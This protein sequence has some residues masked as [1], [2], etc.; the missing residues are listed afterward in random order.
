[1]LC[2]GLNIKNYRTITVNTNLIMLVEKGIIVTLYNWI[3][4]SIWPFHYYEYK[5]WSH[6]VIL[7]LITTHA[8]ICVS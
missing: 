1:M 4:G 3:F 8:Y 6:N 2:D 5:K 7:E